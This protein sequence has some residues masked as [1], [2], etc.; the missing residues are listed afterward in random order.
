MPVDE[1]MM[2]RFTQQK[3]NESR[4]GRGK[5]GDRFNLG[6]APS[7]ITHGGKEITTNYEQGKHED[8]NFED[9]D[10]DPFNALDRVETEGH[11]GG[12][13]KREEA[14]PYGPTGGGKSLG[15]VYR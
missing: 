11:F 9:P 15:D 8:L 10:D 4:A 1:K 2:K 7:A 3:M 13:R 14:N 5:R 12:G 6:D